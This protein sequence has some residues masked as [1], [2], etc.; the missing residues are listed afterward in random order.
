MV[1]DQAEHILEAYFKQCAI[2]VTCRDLA[3]MAATLSNMGH[4]PVTGKGVY[5][6]TAVKAILS[7]MFTCGMYDY[8]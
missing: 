4:N 1:Q 2:L 5:D 7:I 6:H 3:T 8:S